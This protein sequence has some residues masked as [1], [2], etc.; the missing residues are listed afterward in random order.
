MYNGIW[1]EIKYAKHQPGK[2]NRHLP[3]VFERARAPRPFLFGKGHPMR[4]L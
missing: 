2:T 1:Q 3:M 4:K